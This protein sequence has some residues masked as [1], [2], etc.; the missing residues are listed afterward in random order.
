MASQI[1]VVR[2]AHLHA[3]VSVLRQTGVPVASALEKSKLPTWIEEFPDAFVSLPLALEWVGVAGKDFTQSELGFRAAQG[4]TLASVSREF[5]SAL[6]AEPTGLMRLRTFGHLATREDNF[7]DA[8]IRQEG[9]RARIVLAMPRMRTHP[10]VAF[11]EWLNVKGTISVVRSFAGEDWCPIEI[12]FVSPHGIPDAA[13]ESFPNTRFRIGQ[14][15]ASILF[16]SSLLAAR[17]ITTPKH[18]EAELDDEQEPWNLVS[19]LRAIVRPYLAEGYPDIATTAEIVG[20]SKRTLQRKLKE[21]GKTYSG[22]VEEA[23]LG[24]AMENLRQDGARIV[25]VAHA[26]GYENPQHF[27]RAFRRLTGFSPTAYRRIGQP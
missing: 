8:G 4:A 5:R 16:D 25:D 1:G 13:R 7:L 14:P 6:F 10:F 24:L 15:C 27:A 3:Y 21:S 22:I 26:S 11:A 9:R 18:Q 12:T 19:V 17:T 20:F 23:R 2:A